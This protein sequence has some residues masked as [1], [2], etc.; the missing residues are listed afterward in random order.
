[1]E[2]SWT[3]DPAEHGAYVV[4]ETP[5]AGVELVADFGHPLWTAHFPAATGT[6]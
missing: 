5:A 1:M 6:L 3:S 2:Y 4:N